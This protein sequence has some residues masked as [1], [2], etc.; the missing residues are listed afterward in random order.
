MEPIAYGLLS[1]VAG[2][3]I[4]GLLVGAI[5][6][7]VVC[8]TRR[9][10]LPGFLLTVCGFV[11]LLAA[12]HFQGLH[13]LYAEFIWGAAPM[14]LTY[15]VCACAGRALEAWTRLRPVWRALAAFG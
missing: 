14:T 9:S 1:L 3:V 10:I 8:W 4:G 12:D 5:G 6:G 11:L 7:A 2:T 13:S 15:L